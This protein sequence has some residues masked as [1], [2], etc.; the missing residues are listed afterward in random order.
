[1]NVFSQPGPVPGE[2]LARVTGRSRSDDAK[3][4]GMT[5]D[6]FS[7][8][9]RCEES[10]WNMRLPI[11]RFGYWMSRRRCAR[12][13]KTMTRDHDQRDDDHAEDDGVDSAPS[14]PSSRVPTRRCGMFGDDAGK[15]DQRDA[16][17]DAA[18]V[19]CS[20]SHIRNIVPPVSVT[21]AVKRKNKPG[22]MTMPVEPSRPT[23]MP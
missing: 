14:R 15:D 7:L 17:A 1:M 5:P 18:A 6:V 10:P 21:T 13:T 11:C 19:I 12:S 23:A 8:S 3:I 20:P 22:S 2:K 4:G 9:G 16:V